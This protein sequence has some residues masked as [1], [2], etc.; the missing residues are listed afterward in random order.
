MIL[1]KG[2]VP[3]A[4]KHLKVH[5]VLQNKYPARLYSVSKI[6]APSAQAL[7]LVFAGDIALLNFKQEASFT[8]MVPQKGKR[9]GAD[10]FAS[11]LASFTAML[12]GAC[13][14]LCF[15]ASPQNSPKG[16]A[17]RF[18]AKLQCRTAYLH[19]Q[20]YRAALPYRGAAHAKAAKPACALPA[21][22][23][24]GITENRH[25]IPPGC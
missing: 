23:P 25:D 13:P 19:R 12:P 15:S 2:G 7:F 6:K 21:G 16:H 8:A 9:P 22:R 18:S 3:A 17:Y 5:A 11:A 20:K 4:A 24:R 14:Y 10:P 1:R